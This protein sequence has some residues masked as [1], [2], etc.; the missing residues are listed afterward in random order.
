MSYDRLNAFSMKGLDAGSPRRQG[1]IPPFMAGS[2]GFS[3]IELMIALAVG[4]V[5]LAAIYGVFTLQQRT[6]SNQDRLVE[7]Q[8]SARA[9]IDMMVRE[10]RMAGFNPTGMTGTDKPRILSATA[11]SIRFTFDINATG[12][13][14]GSNEDVQY[15]LYTPVSDGIQKLG[16]ATA[17]G[18]QPLAEN[19]QN[20]SFTYTLSDGTQTTAPTSAQLAE[21]TDILIT[22][23]ARTS[24]VDPTTGQYRTLTVTAQVKPRN[25]Q[26]SSPAGT[27][28]TT[29][30]TSVTTT[31]T[32]TTSTTSSTGTTT[33]T[34]T[35][36]STGTTTSTETTSSTATTS[37]TTTST[38]PPVRPVIANQVIV[39]TKKNT[40]SGVSATISVPNNTVDYVDYCEDMLGYYS[41]NRMSYLGSDQYK[42]TYENPKSSGVTVN[43]YFHVVDTLGIAHD[44]LTYSFVTTN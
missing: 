6:F 44:S 14:W 40:V 10:L 16:R 15:Y 36:S 33:S 29:T 7:M 39:T 26:L 35:T 43:Y 41:C 24:Q 42:I 19:I 4:M 25:L 37:S 17:G 20:L 23:T 8:Q 13:T 34:E 9:A 5:V 21:I 18:T 30:T 2:S 27:S 11:N 1:N 28:T 3:L 38:A 32:S 12:H 31:S 22:L